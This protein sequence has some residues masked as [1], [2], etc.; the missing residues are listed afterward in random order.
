MKAPWKCLLAAGLITMFTGLVVSLSKVRLAPCWT[1]A[2][3]LGVIVSGFAV[4]LWLTQEEVAGF[5]EAH[6]GQ[7]GD[8]KHGAAAEK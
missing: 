4:I 1:L 7:T 2:L 3:P 6:H 5:N 8:A